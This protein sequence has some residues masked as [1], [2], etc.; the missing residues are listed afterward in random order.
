MHTNGLAVDAPALDGALNFRKQA[1]KIQE[2][3]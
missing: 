3:V 2:T 1:E